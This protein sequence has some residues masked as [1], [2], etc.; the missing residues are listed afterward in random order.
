M[1]RLPTVEEFCQKTGYPMPRTPSEREFIEWVVKDK[2]NLYY[3][4]IQWFLIRAVMI[5]GGILGLLKVLEFFG[6]WYLLGLV[7]YYPFMAVAYLVVSATA[8]RRIGRK[9]IRL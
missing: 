2:F 1:E 3:F 7:L 4:K 5:S 8:V 9:A 6:I